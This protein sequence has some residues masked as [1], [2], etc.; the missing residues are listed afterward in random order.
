MKTFSTRL[1][2]GILFL[3]TISGCALK[4]DVENSDENGSNEAEKVSAVVIEKGERSSAIAGAKVFI[5]WPEQGSVLED[6]DIY[7]V[8]ETEKFIL[9]NQTE[10][11]RADEISNSIN[12]QHIHLIIDNKPYKAIY[13]SGDPVNIG[14]LSP[15]PH[16]IYV[17]P[18]RSYHESVKEP[19]ASDMLNFYVES[20]EGNFELD[21][22]TPAIFY[23]RPKGEYKGLAAKKI[24]LDFYLH[25]LQ[26]SPGAFNVKYTVTK[27]EKD[28][29]LSDKY[30]ILL[31]EWK[32]AFINNLPEGR[33]KVKIELVDPSGNFV[34]GVTYNGTEREITVSPE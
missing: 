12:G 7:I 19:G 5:R 9:G 14:R 28:G 4:T 25:N 8:L 21:K 30:E 2:V 6:A 34:S 24:M 20:D 29:T 17:F 27:V 15:G 32:P 23:S 11:T 1:A 18:S 31:D 13:Q 3:L 22:N 16:T 26:L 10:N 33:Y